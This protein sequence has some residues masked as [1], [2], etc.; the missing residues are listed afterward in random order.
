[1]AKDFV[2]PEEVR[3][4]HMDRMVRRCLINTAIKERVSGM[5]DLD[6]AKTFRICTQ[7]F[8][9]RL[10]EEKPILAGN[11]HWSARTAGA[12]SRKGVGRPCRGVSG[13]SGARRKTNDADQV[14]YLQKAV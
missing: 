4:K 13:V 14:P 3:E 10:P 8:Q 7:N 12:R 6:R 9:S 5:D 2:F 11:R 1:M